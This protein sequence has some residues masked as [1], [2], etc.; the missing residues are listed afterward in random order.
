MDLCIGI[1]NYRIIIFSTLQTEFTTEI[2]TISP[3]KKYDRN[4]KL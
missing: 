2:K 3:N 1:C 4:M